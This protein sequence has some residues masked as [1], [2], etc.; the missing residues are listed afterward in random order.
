MPYFRSLGVGMS[1]AFLASHGASPGLR[2]GRLSGQEIRLELRMARLSTQEVHLG[3]P[4]GP[5]SAQGGHL[6]VQAESL[7]TQGIHR[8]VP[9]DFLS[10]QEVHLDVQMSIRLRKRHFWGS[11]RDGRG[12]LRVAS[13]P[14]LTP[15][16]PLSQPCPPPSRERGE[17]AI[18]SPSSIFG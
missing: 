7:S 12:T 10:G 1:S 3:I 14:A 16:A 11:G 5:L 18:S 2:A 4:P 8:D 15:L 9:M 6:E 13:G 17:E